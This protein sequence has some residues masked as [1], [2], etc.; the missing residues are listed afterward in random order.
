M[1]KIIKKGGKM[2]FRIIKLLAI[3]IILSFILSVIFS[4]CSTKIYTITT[5]SVNEN[6]LK[7]AQDD[8]YRAK[9]LKSDTLITIAEKNIQDILNNP[10]RSVF[11]ASKIIDSTSTSARFI[12][13][14]G[15]EK[16]ITADKIEIQER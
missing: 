2:K 3:V 5:W 14:E 13:L 11:K 8:L 16:F 4:S 12:D 9:L 6:V 1:A 10:R 7:E 15:K